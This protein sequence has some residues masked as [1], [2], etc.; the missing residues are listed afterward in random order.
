MKK[1]AVFTLNGYFNYGNRLQNYATQEVL[2]SLGFKVETVIVKNKPLPSTTSLI[3]IRINNIRNMHFKEVVNRIL[4]KFWS[5]VNKNK[6]RVLENKRTEIFKKFTVDNIIETKFSI[7]DDYIPN[8]L[9]SNYDYFITGSDQVWNPSF[10][11]GSSIY[12]LT[13]APKSKR[14]AFSPSF[15]VF[16]IPIEHQTNYKKWISDMGHLSVREGAGADI[17]K[18]LTGEKA[19]VLVDP[20]M[21]LTKEQWLSVSNKPTNLSDDKFLLTYFLGGV[22]NEYKEKIKKISEDNNLR[23]INLGDIKDYDTYQTGPAEYIEYINTAS[24]LCT[25]SFHGAIFSII[26]EI[27]FIVFERK[28]ISES[29]FSR[30]ET[31]LRKFNL[32]SRK[33]NNITSDNQVLDVDFSHIPPILEAERNKTLDYL[34]N[35]LHIKDAK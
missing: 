8:E 26:M 29:M 16:K 6:I 7:S 33:V 9:I 28:G 12:F 24:I 4:Y 23:V 20:T 31:L 11:Y 18:Q 30:I 10:N 25:D 17:I 19:L 32:E 5:M 14:I 27:P 34:K 13:F 21:M 3:V 2:K 1:I 35:A 15:G 22:P